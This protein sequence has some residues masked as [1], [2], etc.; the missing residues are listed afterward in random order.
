VFI[1]GVA[2]LVPI[3]VGVTFA[4]TRSSS[5]G[6]ADAGNA[7][8]TS[9]PAAT[10]PAVA[11]GTPTL[12]DELLDARRALDLRDALD[13]ADAYATLFGAYPSTGGA[14]T[15]LCLHPTDA[16][17]AIAKYATNLPVSDGQFAYWYASDGRSVTVLARVQ[18]APEQDD[19]P[20]DLPAALIGAP[21]VCLRGSVGTQ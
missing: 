3:V 10:S 18:T 5:S 2:L 9:V 15:T 11:T 16:G 19:C 17:C 4:L 8:S 1:A 13:A 12:A 21:V 6:T 20:A 14:L 7:V